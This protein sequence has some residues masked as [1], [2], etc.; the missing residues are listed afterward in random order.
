MLVGGFLQGGSPETLL[1][2]LLERGTAKGLMTIVSNDTGT[3]NTNHVKLMKT[4][5]VTGVVA[6]YVG[7]N[8]ESIRMITENPKSV[9]LYPQGTLIE[10][11]RSGGAG[12]GGFLTPVGVG[13][14]IE[15]GKNKVIING[16]EYLFETPLR[17]NVAFVHA[18][19]VD[20]HGNCFM[21][22]STKNYNA[23]MPAAAD[24]VIVEAEEIVAVGEIDPELVTVPG[25]FI[26]AIVEAKK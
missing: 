8:T 16:R 25:I 11:L 20:E 24:Y 14:V 9:T 18:T 12:L 5:R 7:Q 2:A 3:A 22:G 21:R 13:T 4:G 1:A 10:K 19:K 15:K 6:S 23:I 26:D 17:G